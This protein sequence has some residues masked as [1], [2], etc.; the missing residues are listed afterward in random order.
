[1]K[2]IRPEF[3]AEEYHRLR[4]EADRLNISLKQLVHDRAVGAAPTDNPLTAAQILADEISKNREVLNQIIKRETTAEIRLYEDDIIRMDMS[5]TELEGIVSAFIT[6][7]LK[8]V[9]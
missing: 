8:K 9:N 7:I 6:E 3:T 4:F 1:M 2:D 5:M